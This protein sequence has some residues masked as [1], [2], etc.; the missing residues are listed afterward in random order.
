MTNHIAV[1]VLLV[2]EV[3]DETASVLVD[4]GSAATIIRADLWKRVMKNHPTELKLL[5]QPMVATD[6]QSL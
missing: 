1:S 4:I 2:G 3:G 6:G 5:N